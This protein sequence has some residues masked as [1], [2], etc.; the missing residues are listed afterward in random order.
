MMMG[1]PFLRIGETS[2]D[3]ESIGIQSRTA[4]LQRSMLLIGSMQH[5]SITQN[6]QKHLLFSCNIL[7]P[8]IKHSWYTIF[9]AISTTAHDPIQHHLLVFIASSDVWLWLTS[10]ND[11]IP[12]TAIVRWHVHLCSYTTFQTKLRTTLHLRPHLQVLL[13]S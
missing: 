4:G 9:S 11:R 1:K 13:N 10:V 6:N 7:V 8:Q 5:L 3:A 2:Q 12:H